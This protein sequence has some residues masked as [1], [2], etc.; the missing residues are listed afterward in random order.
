M[1]FAAM[2]EFVVGGKADLMFGSGRLGLNGIG[3]A[4]VRPEHGA[5]KI[6]S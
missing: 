6:R 1:L 3:A 2:D 5:P 4:A